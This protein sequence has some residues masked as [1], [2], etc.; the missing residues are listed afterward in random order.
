MDGAWIVVA[1][2]LL[3]ILGVASWLALEKRSPEATL[4]WIVVLG[5]L[6]VVG[7]PIY[8][9]IGPRRLDRKRLR[10]GDLRLQLAAQICQLERGVALPPDVLRQVRLGLHLDEAPVSTAAEIELF[11]D[12]RSAFAAL[13]AGIESA[14]RHVHLETYIYDPDATGRRLL[15]LLAERA[16]AGVRVRLLV[17]DVGARAGARFFAPL[18]AAGGQVA[19]F[20]PPRFPLP[21]RRWIDF[22]THRKIAVI[23]GHEGFLGGMNVSDSQTVGARGAPPW[24]DT[25]L[26]LRGDAVRALQRAFLEN[27][28]FGAG[29]G[30]AGLDDLPPSPPGPHRLQILRSGPDREVHP[31]HE[32]LFAAIAGADERVWATTAYLVPDEPLLVALRSAAHR[33]VDVRLLVPERGDSRFV[34]AAARSYFENL[35]L[36]GVR[37]W[38][39][40]PA[41]L[42]AKTMVVDR[43]L[44]VVGSGN[45]DIRSFRLNFEIAAAIYGTAAADHL[46]AIFER[47]LTSARPVSAARLAARPLGPRLFDAGA[48]LFAGLL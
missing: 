30:P 5:F 47:D 37:I 31:I 46:A 23:D 34:A 18:V 3:W 20:N 22:R 48:R 15:E 2:E 36:S 39:Y 32:F 10:Y 4:A 26:R 14:R 28:H 9:L 42:H 43:E 38:E 40:G 6:P 17:D 41:I 24:R 1:L 35:L 8:L 21:W 13:A 44:A 27:W 33:G 25:H 12:G 16:R 29:P 19:R 45:L 7:V 11:V